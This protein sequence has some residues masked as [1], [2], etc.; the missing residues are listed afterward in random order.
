MSH[1]LSHISVEYTLAMS[2]YRQK[3]ISQKWSYYVVYDVVCPKP[4]IVYDILCFF[5]W[6]L[7]PTGPAPH[8]S[9]PPSVA[10]DNPPW[11][12]D[13]KR[14]FAEHA[15]SPPSPMSHYSVSDS[16][17]SVSDSRYF[18]AGHI[19]PGCPI[20]FSLGAVGRFRSVDR[21]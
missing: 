1:T 20:S 15:Y 12:S 19:V 21:F 10:G 5:K 17:Y 7:L 16:R 8:P 2:F 6:T 13:D 14:D 3:K 4:N 11:N 9:A 18:H